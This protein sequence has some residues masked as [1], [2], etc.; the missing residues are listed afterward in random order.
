M[1]Y[2]EGLSQ[3]EIANNVHMDRSGISKKIGEYLKIL[4]NMY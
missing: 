2:V 1:Y 4:Q 3:K